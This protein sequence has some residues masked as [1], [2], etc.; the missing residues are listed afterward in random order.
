MQS[1]EIRAGKIYFVCCRKPPSAKKYKIY[2]S[3]AD[4]SRKIYFV[5]CSERA[6]A[7]KYKIYF[8]TAA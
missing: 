6:A 4:G 2:F 1:A 8:S 3:A 7:K 5:F